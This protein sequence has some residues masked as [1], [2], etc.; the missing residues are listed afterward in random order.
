MLS[1]EEIIPLAK[2]RATSFAVTSFPCAKSSIVPT[3][4]SAAFSSALLA[5]GFFMI[6]DADELASE[7]VAAPTPPDTAPPIVPHKNP[8]AAP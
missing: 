2:S 4:V 8:S 1:P 7:P 6:D 5:N 3:V